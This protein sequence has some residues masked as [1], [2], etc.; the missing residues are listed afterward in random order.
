M[1]TKGIKGILVWGR[2]TPWPPFQVFSFLKCASVA[3]RGLYGRGI[4]CRGS[5]NYTKYPECLARM[6]M[7]NFL[8]IIN[9]LKMQLR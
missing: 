5:L 7:F 9:I 3:G 1:E 2:R 4:P 8:V 6:I